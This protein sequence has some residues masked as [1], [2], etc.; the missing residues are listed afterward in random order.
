MT[1]RLTTHKYKTTLQSKSDSDIIICDFKIRHID[2]RDI[3]IDYPETDIIVILYQIDTNRIK[4]ETFTLDNQM[5]SYMLLLNNNSYKIE[6]PNQIIFCK[7]NHQI[8]KDEQPRK[9]PKVIIQTWETKD[10]D[11]CELGFSKKALMK[12]NPGFDYKLFD[13]NERREFI[14]DNFNE[15]VLNA[16]D[17]MKAKA[18]QCDIWRYCYLYING[19][20]YFDIKTVPL[21]PLYVTYTKDYEMLLVTE[22]AGISIFNGI[23]ATMPGHDYFKFLIM[24]CVLN[25]ENNFYGNEPL[26]I[27]SPRL[28]YKILNQYMNNPENIILKDEYENICFMELTD[29]LEHQIL[30]PKTNLLVFYRIFSSYYKKFINKDD[31][32]HYNNLWINREMYNNI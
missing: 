30:L 6:Q 15:R 11:K 22:H 3:S 27:T 23:M 13:V 20:Y 8:I 21:K 25:I 32:L 1:S 18:F 10:I 14:K 7:N 4:V 9:I 24:A 19:G 2:N 28:C 12:L 29:K 17:K 5:H 31:P 26:D 16:Y